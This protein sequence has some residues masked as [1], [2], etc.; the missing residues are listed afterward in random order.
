MRPPP[1]GQPRFANAPSCVLT[2]ACWAS[3]AG[4]RSE[5]QGR[6][7]EEE[8]PLSHQPAA[9]PHAPV[10]LCCRRRKKS[11]KEKKEKKEKSQT[12]AQDEFV[13]EER[14]DT[15]SYAEITASVR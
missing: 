8:V 7:G 11:K 3:R 15:K 4:R 9:V 13:E 5:N 14:P 2:F 1:T 12:L 6:G 10:T